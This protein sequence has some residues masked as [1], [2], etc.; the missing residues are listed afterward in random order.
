MRF[1]P[2]CS[3]ICITAKNNRIRAFCGKCMVFIAESESLGRLALAAATHECHTERRK[4]QSATATP[5]SVT[6]KKINK[7]NNKKKP[8]EP[9]NGCIFAI[10]SI[11]SAGSRDSTL[12]LYSCVSSYIGFSPPAFN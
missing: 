5:A 4:P 7:R 9:L 11:H 8:H 1:K 2:P 6:E 3:S 12:T 10:A